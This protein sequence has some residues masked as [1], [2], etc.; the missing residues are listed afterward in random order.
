[1][2]RHVLGIGV[3]SALLAACTVGPDYV[4]A[5]A[6]RAET[7][8]QAPVAAQV[9]GRQT[10]AEREFWRAFNDPQ[11][12]SLVERAL[13]QNHDVRIALARYDQAR[14]LSRDAGYARLPQLDANAQ[15]E[16]VR[17]S[18]D[19]A[20][21]VDR[22]GRDTHNYVGG[23]GVSWELDLFGRL[24]RASEASRA[25]AQ[26][27][28]ADLAAMQV[29]IAAS[30][31]QGWFELRG[32]Q[33]QLDI[34]REN[35]ATQERTLK[36]LQARTEAGFSD[37]FDVDRGRA[38]LEATLAR[39]PSLEA[40]EAVAA[41]RIAVLVGATPESMAAELMTSGALPTLPAAPLPGTPSDLLRRRPD[42]AAAERRVAAATAR[43]GV[44][45]ADLFPRFSLGALFGTQALGSGAL[46]A[47]DSETRVLSLGLDGGFLNVGRVRAR[48]AAANAQTAQ[49]LAAYQQTVLRALEDTE[50]ALVR[51]D[52]SRTESAH[53]DQAAQAG[54]RAAQVARL[55]LDNGAIDTL[56]MLEAE[57]TRLDSQDAA[58]QGRVR[59]GVAMVQLYAA[60]A[61]GW[62][63]YVAAESLP[64]PS[65]GAAAAE[66]A[67][68]LQEVR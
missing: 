57:R 66:R 10:T 39:I 48:I 18:A 17:S 42:V 60:L 37:A 55:R 45:T 16:R 4:R 19:Q 63:E 52:R 9:A 12:S 56:D 22:D 65:P 68:A 26:A 36:L 3:A 41:N 44:A 61:G 28:S 6:P 50:N 5:D 8:V 23:L 46:F 59:S 30:V 34:A 54:T 32:L 13:L 31:A 40:A 67:V 38:Q 1:M 15:A 35:A 21:G 58:I 24:R 33:S 47:R 29:A 43:V 2:V 11:L 20:P 49:D 27:A 62:P 64:P 7:F 25:D 53:L 14:A 51:V